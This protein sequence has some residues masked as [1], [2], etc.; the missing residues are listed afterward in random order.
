M[1]KFSILSL[2]LHIFIFMLA[3][4]G[5]PFSKNKD[6]KEL[7]FDIVEELPKSNR[8]VPK[9]TLKNNS[10]SLDK[11]TPKKPI[12]KFKLRQNQNQISLKKL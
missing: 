5:F 8:S 10:K 7:T 11:S 2:I 4:Y 9:K 1:I 12:K 3:Y 6:V